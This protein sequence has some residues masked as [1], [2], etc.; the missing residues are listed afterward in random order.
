VDGKFAMHAEALVGIIFE[1]VGGALTRGRVLS[2][3]LLVEIGRKD[4]SLGLCELGGFERICLVLTHSFMN[5]LLLI[6]T[7]LLRL[8]ICKVTAL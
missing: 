2:N 8:L 1:V 5:F 4:D 3:T 7:N 6:M